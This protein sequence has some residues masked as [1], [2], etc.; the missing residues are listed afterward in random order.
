MNVIE[1]AEGTITIEMQPEEAMD[2]AQACD[3][4]LLMPYDGDKTRDH[5][6]R[7]YRALFMALT[8]AGSAQHSI[9]GE[10]EQAS[11]SLSAF[12]AMKR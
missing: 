7:L 4:V 8:V 1:I 9:V 2:I 10:K 11:V 5:D 3:R 6:Y 12:R